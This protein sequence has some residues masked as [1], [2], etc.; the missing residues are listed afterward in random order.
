[1]EHLRTWAKYGVTPSGTP[2]PDGPQRKNDPADVI[3]SAANY[4]HASGAPAHWQ[5]AIF[6]YNHVCATVATAGYVNP[7]AH[8]QNL[9]P[10]RIDMGV[11]Y[12]EGGPVRVTSRCRLC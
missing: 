1:M 3:F 11:D 9:H 7:L 4:L 6:I 8:I 10:E 5:G 12:S 2:A